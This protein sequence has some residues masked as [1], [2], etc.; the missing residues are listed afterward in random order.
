MPHSVPGPC[1]DRALPALCAHTHLFPGARCRLLKV[2]DPEGFAGAP[3]PVGV[4]LRFSDGAVA[5]A[6]LEVAE[7]GGA[8][9]AVDAYVTAAGTRIAARLWSVRA[10]RPD[11]DEV[12]VRI[13]D[14]LGGTG[15][16]TPVTD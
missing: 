12:E 11:G 8:V 7:D 6:E 15:P 2:P 16:G 10:L 4:A 13:G 3:R 5:A 14:R 9:L 1:E